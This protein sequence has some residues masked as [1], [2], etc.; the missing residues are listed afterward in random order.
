MTR[1]SG[2][3][4]SVAQSCPT[5]C[6]SMSRSTPG[7]AV[8]HQL[9][10]FT[11]THVHWVSDA[12]QPSHPLSSA[13]R[14]HGSSHLWQ[15]SCGEDLICKGKSELERPPG[16]ARASTPKPKSVCFTISWL[17]PTLL[18]LTG[19]YPGPPFSE[20]NQLRVLV[21]KFPGHNR[22][23]SIQTPLMTFQLAWQVCLDSCSYACDYSQPPNQERHRK[24]K[25]F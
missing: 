10:E 22:S 5:L 15:R 19:G 9:P 25:I 16:P 18:T 20:E 7:L 21:N 23:V 14:Q 1:R 2:Q 11:Q 24:L 4:G 12:I 13:G 8:H 3:L 6:Y 17:S